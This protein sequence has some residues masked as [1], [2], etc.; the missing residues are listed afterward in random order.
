[1]FKLLFFEL[2]NFYTYIVLCSFGNDFFFFIEQI[3]KKLVCVIYAMFGSWEFTEILIRIYCKMDN[4]TIKYLNKYIIINLIEICIIVNAF[5][6]GYIH[7]TEI[8]IRA[9]TRY[10]LIAIF[11]SLTFQYKCVLSKWKI[12]FRSMN[13]QL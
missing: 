8:N 7:L 9:D 12:S 11:T 2:N 1:M 3:I 13:F 6:K 10:V 5:V 4:K